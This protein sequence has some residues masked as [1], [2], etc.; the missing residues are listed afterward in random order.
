MVPF[1]SN[2]NL[3]IILTF[4]YWAVYFESHNLHLC[5]DR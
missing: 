5:W 1:T 3:C 4:L 2:Y